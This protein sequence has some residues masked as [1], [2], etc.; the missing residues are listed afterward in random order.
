MKCLSLWQPWAEMVFRTDHDGI[1]LKPDETRGWPTVVRGRIA[2]HASK[3]PLR[4]VFRSFPQ[5]KWSLSMCGVREHEMAFG[6]IIGTV[7]LVHC[8][9][10]AVTAID[11]HDWQRCWGDYRAI[12]DDGKARFAFVLKNPTRLP[13]PIPCVGRQGFFNVDL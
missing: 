8:L 13:E 12:G 2:I 6:A 10:A 3:K 11:R 5:L 9:P 4:E 1:A 7:E